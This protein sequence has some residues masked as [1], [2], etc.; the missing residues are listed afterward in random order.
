MNPNTQSIIVYRNPMEQQVW[1]SGLVGPIFLAAIAGVIAMVLIMKVVEQVARHMKRR[2]R[3]DYFTYAA[4]VAS[5][6]VA[7]KVFGALTI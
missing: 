1:E 7:V 3:N 5:T 2:I 4:M 6:L